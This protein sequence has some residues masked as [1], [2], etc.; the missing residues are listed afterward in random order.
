[1]KN[2]MPILPVMLASACWGQAPAIGQCATVTPVEFHIKNSE[3]MID[4]ST[5]RHFEASYKLH[6]TAANSE[7]FEVFPDSTYRERVRARRGL[8][9][10][11][12]T[13]D[14][15]SGEQYEACTLAKKHGKY[16][17][18]KDAKGKKHTFFFIGDDDDN[19]GTKF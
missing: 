3:A 17:Q 18:L 12:P 16:L 11:Q 9:E 10:R 7:D 19:E 1:M 4:G 13:P 14:V 15:H 5:V 8:A 2:I 6:F